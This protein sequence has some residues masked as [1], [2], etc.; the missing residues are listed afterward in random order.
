MAFVFSALLGAFLG[1]IWLATSGTLTCRCR[2][3]EPCWPSASE[4]AA[5][6]TTLRGNLLKVRPVAH[7]CHDPFY[8]H[9]A[10]QK[11]PGLVRDSG[12]RASQPGKL[13]H[14][15]RRSLSPYSSMLTERPGWDGGRTRS[16]TG[17]DLGVWLD[18]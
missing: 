4:W 9:F 17:L 15:L 10:C 2:P 18:R 6:N 8:D 14:L 1:C 5:L 16:L 13:M 3:G 12:W 11:L 7:V